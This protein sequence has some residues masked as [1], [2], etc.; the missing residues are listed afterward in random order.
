MWRTLASSARASCGTQPQEIIAGAVRIETAAVRMM[1]LI[2]PK[3]CKDYSYLTETQDLQRCGAKGEPSRS[4]V[5]ARPC[6]MDKGPR[7]VAHVQPAVAIPNHAAIG[8]LV[9]TPP[10]I[11]REG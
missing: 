1:P 9:V 6:R 11:P 3:M 5:K 8:V 4:T 7:A 2:S 10:R